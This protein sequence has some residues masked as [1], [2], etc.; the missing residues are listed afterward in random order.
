MMEEIK[1]LLDPSTTLGALIIGVISGLISGLLLG[2]FTGKKYQ[3]N[4]FKTTGNQS[5]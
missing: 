4:K 2:F 3:T 1:D 5:R